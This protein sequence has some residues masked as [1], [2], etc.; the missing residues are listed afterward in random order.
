MESDRLNRL[1]AE[2]IMGWF[3]DSGR[4]IEVTASTKKPGSPIL[5]AYQH[6]W[7]PTKDL[8]Q[9]WEVA[10]KYKLFDRGFYLAKWDDNFWVICDSLDDRLVS[11]E[12]A[13]MVLIKACLYLKGAKLD[14]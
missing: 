13:S 3:L 1:T 12:T 10:E 14:E 5:K 7:N 2:Q 6:D 8:L 4:W 11:A 9:A